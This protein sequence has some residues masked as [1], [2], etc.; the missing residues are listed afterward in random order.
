LGKTIDTFAPLGPF[1]VTADEISWPVELDIQSRLNGHVMQQANTR[2]FIFP[3]ED[4]IAHL[5]RFCTLRPGDLIFTG[6]PAGV[7]AARVPPV[8]L[9]P[10]D[11]VEVE[12]ERIGRLIN[13]VVAS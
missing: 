11:V 2:T 6:T 10:G 5:S 4:L 12:I 9:K 7:G 3:I 8:F 13:P 1:L